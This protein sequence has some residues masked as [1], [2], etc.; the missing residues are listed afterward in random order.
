M[1]TSNVDG[2]RPSHRRELICTVCDA[3]AIGFNFSVITCMCCKAFFRRNALYGLSALQCRYLSDN[4]VI[5]SKS[6]RDCSYC[7][8][9]KCFDVGMKKEL[10]LSEEA[11]QIKREKILANRQMTLNAIRPIQ[12]L[13]I[14]KDLQLSSIQ[15]TYLNNIN[16]AYEDQCRLPLLE[17]DR[18]K[19]ETLTHQPI[20]NRIKIQHY[21]H[22]FQ[23]SE[24][25]LVNFFNRLPEFQQLSTDR[26]MI[27]SKHNMRFLL[28]VSLIETLSDQLPLWPAINLL[29]QTMFGKYL[30]DRTSLLLRLF[31]DQIG[32]SK[33]IRLLLVVL[34]FSTSNVTSDFNIDTLQIHRIQMKYIELLWLYF[35]QRYSEHEACEKFSNIVRHCLHLQTIGHLAD[36]K[37]EQ[38]QNGN[39]SLAIT[40]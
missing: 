10:I 14:R 4:C 40:N 30:L 25:L 38:L 22:Y 9:K 2:N 8:L 16:N 21:F 5:N 36:L 34:L 11:K 6:R 27:L 13:V 31:K 19:Y 15:L 3:P 28:R 35:K 1:N 7:R 26:Q 39:R 17:Y 23:T 29:L 20:K 24:S 37:R 12:S 18:T 33:G 32:D